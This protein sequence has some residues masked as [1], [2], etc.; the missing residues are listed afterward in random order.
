MTAGILVLVVVFY[1]APA[2]GQ[3]ATSTATSTPYD[4]STWQGYR[5]WAIR[6]AAANC[7]TEPPGGY[8]AVTGA[9]QAKFAYRSGAIAPTGEYALV[10]D[11]DRDRILCHTGPPYTHHS[12]GEEVGLGRR[13]AEL[14]LPEFIRTVVV[15]TDDQ[16]HPYDTRTIDGYREGVIRFAASL[17]DRSLPNYRYS[18]Y[19]ARIDLPG[20]F[21]AVT[22]T[23]QVKFAWILKKGFWIGNVGMADGVYGLTTGL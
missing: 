9:G 18:S 3:M 4:V 7:A 2:F 15:S 16:P 5:E 14:D 17:C 23:S 6:L 11:C 20:G 10:P 22:D 1:T 13:C 12:T 21:P 8:P 19:P